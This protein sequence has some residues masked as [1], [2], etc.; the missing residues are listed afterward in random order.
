MAT[1]APIASAEQRDR[2]HVLILKDSI[3]GG[4]RAAQAKAPA[5]SP[6]LLQEDGGDTHIA[7]QPPAADTNQRSMWYNT[8]KENTLKHMWKGMKIIHG[9]SNNTSGL[10]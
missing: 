6:L 3:M 7:G 10:A 9:T 1:A 8:V 4:E 2:N 5:P